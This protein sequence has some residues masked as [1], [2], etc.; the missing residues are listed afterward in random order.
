LNAYNWILTND[1]Y[2]A[3]HLNPWDGGVFI[4]MFAEHLSRGLPL[5]FPQNYIGKFRKQLGIELTNKE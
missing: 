5:N 1:V 3:Q 2:Y 4:L